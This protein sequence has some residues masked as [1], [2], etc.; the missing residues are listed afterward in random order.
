VIRDGAERFVLVEQERSEKASSFRKIPLA[1][2]VQSGGDSQV[3]RG[4]LVPGDRV[5]CQG[6]RQLGRLFSQGVLKLS[7]EAIQDIGLK[8]MTVREGVIAKT[9]SV[10]GIVSLPPSKLARVSPQIS[11]RIQ[12]IMIEPGAS[13]RAGQTVAVL[14]ST[15]FHSPSGFKRASASEARI[16]VFGRLGSQPT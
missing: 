3:L 5:L 12:Q 4:D 2:G 16:R 6:S 11:G 14:S 8:T 1:I 9:L 10:D 7:P 13:V 15:E